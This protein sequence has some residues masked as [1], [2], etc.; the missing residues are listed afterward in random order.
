VTHNIAGLQPYP[1]DIAWISKQYSV[2]A[3]RPVTVRLIAPA[4]SAPAELGSRPYCSRGAA[5]HGQLD[6][7]Q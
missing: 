2:P 7:E 4:E 5:P 6:G 1:L 3:V